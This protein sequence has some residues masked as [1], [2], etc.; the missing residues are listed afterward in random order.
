MYYIIYKTTNTVNGKVYIG[1]HK[2]KDLNDGY[3]GSGKLLCRAIEKYGIDNFAREIVHLCKTEDNMNAKE[4]EI[5]TEDFCLREDTYNLCVGGHG[6]F[7]Y[8]NRNKLN[9][10]NK[11]KKNIYKK[12]SKKLKGRKNKKYS[13][14][15]KE[16]HR[17]GLV[18]YD[19]FRGKNHKQESKEKISKALKGRYI[20]SKNS[21]YGTIWINNGKE[22]KKIKKDTLIPEGWYKGQFTIPNL[23]QEIVL[24]QNCIQYEFDIYWW[25]KFLKSEKTVSEFVR[26]E[27]PK[28][29][30]ESF[31]RMKRRLSIK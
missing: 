3:L 29:S 30:R 27:F 22:N 11:D 24:C 25:N 15:L 13:E 20:G 8:I 31:Y 23:T 9:N 16:R 14:I 26:T 7:S 6:G 4:R 10:E 19:T 28:N 1:K 5:V 17:Q 18:K 2:T 21:Q 12:I